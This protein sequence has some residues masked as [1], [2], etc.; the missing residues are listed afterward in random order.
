MASQLERRLMASLTNHFALKLGV[1][2]SA[3]AM[4]AASFDIP[5]RRSSNFESDGMRYLDM[6][7]ASRKRDP[8]DPRRAKIPDG[9]KLG[10]DPNERVPWTYGHV[11]PHYHVFRQ[12]W[13]EPTLLQR[14]FGP[15]TDAGVQ[16]VPKTVDHVE[17]GWNGS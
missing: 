13:P 5:A 7:G 15:K 10:V 6:G 9:P 12:L 2:S 1:S 14:K 11:K 17:G 8:N 3:P 16:K 4:T